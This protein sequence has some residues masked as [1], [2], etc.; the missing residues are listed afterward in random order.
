MLSEPDPASE[1]KV[2]LR[3]GRKSWGGSML[4]SRGGEQMDSGTLKK[5]ISGAF[6]LKQLL[7]T[8]TT[9]SIRILTD[10]K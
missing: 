10:D 2:R 6:F 7:S 3:L 1:A 5:I 4:R 9:I 8:F